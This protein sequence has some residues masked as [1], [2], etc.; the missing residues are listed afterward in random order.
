LERHSSDAREEISL[1]DTKEFFRA[2]RLIALAG[3]IH[4]AAE[5]LARPLE[6]QNAQEL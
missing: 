4:S 6:A 3:T 2:L 1:L 5:L